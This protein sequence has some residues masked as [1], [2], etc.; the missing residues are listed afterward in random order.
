MGGGRHRNEQE[1]ACLLTRTKKK[2]TPQRRNQHFPQVPD[3]FT[4]DPFSSLILGSQQTVNKAEQSREKPP[5]LAH[6]GFLFSFFPVCDCL[7]F[8]ICFLTCSFMIPFFRLTLLS[9]IG[10]SAIVLINFS[11][12]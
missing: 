1:R 4:T 3:N 6:Q 8:C 12:L 9:S 10:L 2:S 11:Y 5:F 7:N